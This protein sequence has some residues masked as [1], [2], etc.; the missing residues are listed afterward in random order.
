MKLTL[1]LAYSQLRINRSRTFWTIAGIVLSTAMITAVSGF[2]TS[3]DV[4][5]KG[6][7]GG[8]RYYNSMYNEILFGLVLS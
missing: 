2:V 4:M 8:S 1:S 7:V 5:F 3:A 6:L